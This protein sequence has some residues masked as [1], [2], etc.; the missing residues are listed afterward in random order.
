[1][2]RDA[3]GDYDAE[4]EAQEPPAERRREAMA[5]PKMPKA[6]VRRHKGGGNY[7]AGHPKSHHTHGPGFKSC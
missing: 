5:E 7:G 1:M 2:K 3:D 4:Y 6:K